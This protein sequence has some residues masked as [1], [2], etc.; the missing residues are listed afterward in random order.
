MYLANRQTGCRIAGIARAVPRHSWLLIVAHQVEGG[1]NDPSRLNCAAPFR[2]RLASTTDAVMV[3]ASVL[4]LCR[5]LSGAV[6]WSGTIAT[7]LPSP[8][9][10]C[11]APFRERLVKAAIKGIS[12]DWALQLCRPLSGAVRRPFVPVAVVQGPASIV[13]PPFGSG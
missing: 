8:C 10:N 5:L 4:Q 13:P 3:I 12:T 6:S 9:F 11:A 7:T 2:G 1:Q